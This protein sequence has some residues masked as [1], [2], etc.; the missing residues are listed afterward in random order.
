VEQAENITFDVEQGMSAR[1]DK[2]FVIFFVL[3]GTYLLLNV[4]LQQDPTIA[5]KYGISMSQLRLLN[6]AVVIP[7]VSIWSLA[8]Y[9]F[10]KLFAYSRKIGSSTDGAGFQKLSRGVMWLVYSL[11]I[12]SILGQ[13][14]SY[15]GRN[16][17]LYQDMTAV[18]RHYVSV[19][20][21]LV[22]FTLIGAGAAQLAHLTKRRI[23]LREMHFGAFALILISVLFAFIVSRRPI[24]A[25]SMLRTYYLPTWVVLSTLVIPYLYAWYRGVLGAYH[26]LMYRSHVKG[27]IYKRTLGYL[28]AG[29]IAAIST[30]VLMQMMIAMSAGLNKLALAPLMTVIYTLLL[31]MALS[32]LLIALGAKHLNKIEDA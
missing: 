26:I 9:G 2:K 23:S 3:T 6:I 1:F 12:T 31:L 27:R 21:A 14:N 15:V 4:V 30:S 32:Y 17:P 19:L 28:A 11:P 29:L 25:A 24:D 16:Y 8:Y 22:A 18:T 13:L 10:S 5:Q 7:I 20:L